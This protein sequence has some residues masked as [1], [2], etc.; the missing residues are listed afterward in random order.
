MNSQEIK[1]ALMEYFRFKRNYICCSEFYLYSGRSDV[2]AYDYKNNLIDIEIKI[3]KSD[4]KKDFEKRKHIYYINSDKYNKNYLFPN[5][6]IFCV[7]RELKEFAL[8][9]LKDYSM[10]GLLSI[11]QYNEK[12]FI[13][14]EKRAKLLH[15]EKINK[16]K[17][18]HDIIMR[19]NTEVITRTKEI[20]KLKK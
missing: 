6:F 7:P 15:K 1:L 20:I 19:L 4:F 18:L 17:I 9:Y 13:Y 5:K 2:V 3:S 10:Y 16:D 8:E 14:T 11:D 12:Y